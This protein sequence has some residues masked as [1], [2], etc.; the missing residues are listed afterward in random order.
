MNEWEPATEGIFFDLPEEIY[1]TAPGVNNSTLKMMRLSPAHYINALENPK[2]TDSPALQ[3]GRILH[4]V[5]L[6]PLKPRPYVVRPDGMKFTTKEGRAWKDEQTLPV[7]DL[8]QH[9]AISA[10][11]ENVLKHPSGH[12]VFDYRCKTE[13]AFFKRDELTGLLLKAK[14]DVAFFEGDSIT[15]ILDVKTTEDASASA[16]TRSC[17]NFGY[18]R[19][20]AFY[21]LVTG[22]SDFTFIAVEKSPPYSVQAFRLSP[23]SIANAHLQIRRDLNLVKE[24][25]LKDEWPGY[26]TGITEL[27]VMV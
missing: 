8:D 13:V 23:S 17:N 14:I 5:I 4:Q 10:M 6:E 19:Q 15:K 24:C 21:E 9:D 11:S 20:A 26:S 22:C 25:I 7:I 12:L 2:H 27:E 18:A 3:F 16:F 1:R